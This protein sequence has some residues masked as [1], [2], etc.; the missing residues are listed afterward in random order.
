MIAL[1]A[2]VRILLWSEPI[3]MRKGIDGLAM[4]V[5]NAD[6]DVFS[7]HLFV[8][9]SRRRHQ[10]RILTWQ[11][12]GFLLLSKRLEQGVFGLPHPEPGQRRLTLDSAQLAMLLDGV[13]LRVVARSKVWQPPVWR[14]TQKSV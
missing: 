14:E 6:E 8:F 11:R 12:G 3:D 2:S 13:D 10:L 7:G 1:P 4:L 5:R 9:V